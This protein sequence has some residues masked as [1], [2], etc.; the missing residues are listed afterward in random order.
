MR[1]LAALILIS[2]VVVSLIGCSKP[3]TEPGIIVLRMT[4]W[5]KQEDL[6][7]YK[8]ALKEFYKTH[9]NIR[10]E[11]ESVPWLRM[12]DKLL[13]STAGGRCPDVSRVSS[14]Y[15]TP[16]AAKGLLEDLE[17][18]IE[19]DT[20]FDIS[21]FYAPAV[22]SWGKY[23]GKI[24][25]IPGDVDIYAMY[26][27]KT[28]F[29]KYGV[30]YPDETWT[31]ETF[32]ANAK[33]LSKNLDKDDKLEQWGCV[34]DQTWQAYVWQNGGS[35]LNADNTRC[36][37]DEPA[38][39]EALQWM[40]DL[41]TK[42]HVAPTAADA[43]DI[44]PQKLF[45][46]GQIG[47]Y[48]SG[49]WAAGLIFNKEITTFDYDVA[50]LPMGKKRAS[51]IGGACWGILKGGKHKK[52]AWELVKFMTSPSMQ[53]HF[54]EKK[55]IIP[56]RKSVAESGAYLYLKDKPRKKQV[57]IDAIEYGYPLPKVECS[58]EMNYLIA[59][60]ITLAVLGKKTAKECCIKAAKYA[61]EILMFNRE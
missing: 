4:V 20:E 8:E 61:D 10:V 25:A 36:T 41:R 17:P 27:N 43:A 15:F 18:Y 5:D 24:Y 32:L 7:F 55:Q 56:S 50:P 30:P 34:P 59:N 29:D 9:P 6:D 54:A 16:C 3:K 60:E 19:K 26:Y 39:Y 40:S 48:I 42:H 44:G 21:D 31:W 2:A 46:N 11:I 47:M 1:K 35:I 58:V 51:F 28:M 14:T 57:F 12:F 33:R 13:V 49:S 53:K 23:K 22:E 52:E 45:T 38:A 37:L